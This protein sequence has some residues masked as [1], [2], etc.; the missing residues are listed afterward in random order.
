[1]TKA[2]LDLAHKTIGDLGHC[3]HAM[4]QYGNARIAGI[5]RVAASLLEAMVTEAEVLGS[6]IGNNDDVDRM[7]EGMKVKHAPS[8]VYRTGLTGG[9]DHG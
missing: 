1:M 9:D 6:V 2:Q 5:M 7:I 4:E 3:V 8:D